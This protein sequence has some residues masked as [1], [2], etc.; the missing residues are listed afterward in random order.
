MTKILSA[1]IV[2][3]AITFGLTAQTETA[4]KKVKL[5]NPKF[6]I[7]ADNGIIGWQAFNRDWLGKL[8][9]MET[10]ED[11]KF[12]RITPL[13]SPTQKNANG[14]P[15]NLVLVRATPSFK[16]EVGKKV[17]IQFEFR[18]N[19]AKPEGGPQ[20]YGPGGIQYP[21]SFRAMKPAAGK[22]ISYSAEYT[23]KPL[24]DKSPSG[25]FYLGFSVENNS[26]DLRNVSLAVEK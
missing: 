17:K 15:R 13:P 11:G 7:P 10:Q 8:E 2:F 23:I 12:L 18:A 5:A 1:A 14:S 22:W 19:T 9:I 20:L 16:G 4:F 21:P 25:T 3:M 6:E 26:V 24:K